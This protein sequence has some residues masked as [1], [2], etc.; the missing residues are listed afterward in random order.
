MI[1]RCLKNWNKRYLE[2]RLKC[3]EALARITC[4]CDSVSVFLLDFMN[5]DFTRDESD[6]EKRINNRR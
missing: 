5:N 2:C 6:E 4:V 3:E 1:A